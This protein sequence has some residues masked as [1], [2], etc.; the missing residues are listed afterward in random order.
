MEQ[1]KNRFL[2]Y[3]NKRNTFRIV[4]IELIVIGLLLCALL[5]MFVHVDVRLNGAQTMTVAVGETFTDPGATATADGRTVDV[6][7]SG[8]VDTSTP[9]TY[10]LCYE[11]RFLLSTG[12]TY[13]TVIVQ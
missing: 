10:T 1:D 7:V 13:R 12:K 5:A 2:S 8:T 6:H 9:G 4:V 3:F 11:A